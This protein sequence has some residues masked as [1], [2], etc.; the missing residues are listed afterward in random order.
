MKKLK[1]NDQKNCPKY[2]SPY[3]NTSKITRR[4]T[5]FSVIYDVESLILTEIGKPSLR[6]I[7]AMDETNFWATGLNLLKE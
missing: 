3:Q 6:F 4:E 5:P 1:G 7:Y 2:Y